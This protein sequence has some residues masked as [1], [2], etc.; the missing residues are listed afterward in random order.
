MNEKKAYLNWPTY[1]DDLVNK[2]YIDYRLKNLKT[3][4][5]SG[6]ESADITELNDK[7]NVLEKDITNL[8][9]NKLNKTT[10]DS[11]IADE[12]TPTKD[13]IDSKIESYYQSDDPSLTWTSNIEK[14]TH[15]G[16]IW[17]NS[18][19]QKTY[20]Y[21]KDDTTSPIQYYWQWQNV[22][23]ELLNNVNT[24]ST[25]YSGIIPTNYIAGDYWIIPLN[26]YNNSYNIIASSSGHYINEEIDIGDYILTI[27]EVDEDGKILSSTLDIPSKSNYNIQQTIVVNDINIELISAS[28][29]ILPDNCYGGTICVAI[30]SNSEY[31]NLDWINRNDYTPTDKSESEYI[32]TEKLDDIIIETNTK[33]ISEINK[34]D[35]AIELKLSTIETTVSSN[36]SEIDANQ[37]YVDES[38]KSINASLEII[39]NKITTTVSTSGGN[40]LLKNSVG[41]KNTNFWSIINDKI[42][43]YYITQSNKVITIS[44]KYK[45]IGTAESII[46]LHSSDTQFYTLLRLTEPIDN[47]NEFTYQ[48][49]SS[50]NTPYLEFNSIFEGIQDNDA[51]INGISGSKL[52]FDSGLIITDLMI[53]Y[54]DK[55]IWTPYTDEIYGKSHSLDSNGLDLIDLSS[56]KSLHLDSNSIDFLD[57]NASIGALFSK[58]MSMTDNIR[59][60]NSI[61]IGDLTTY[62]LDDNN[63]L[64]Y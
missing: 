31:N 51:E 50:V 18:T 55:Q 2:A 63:I 1:D 43:Q 41:F 22:P 36:T 57:S 54:G 10:Y 48:Y 39:N 6:G 29:F 62:K 7:V 28:D 25:F 60:N 59:I 19:T 16:D 37:A 61:L 20:T 44:F 35:T 52:L 33:T 32:T 40:N 42:R 13:L 14:E 9:N 34:L 30:N 46:T 58:D 21:R 17:Y 47:W 4:P 26:C 53:N 24:K 5:N 8:N 23:I 64:E 27:T 45:K 56:N 3:S 11:F 49:T 38:I 15:I 12:Y